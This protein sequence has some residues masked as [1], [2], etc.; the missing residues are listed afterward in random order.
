MH[1]VELILTLSA[2]FIAALG[3]GYIT[4]RLGWSPIV[5]YLIAESSWGRIRRDLL[6]TAR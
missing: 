6:R 2:G 3:L 1:S 4:H 5:G